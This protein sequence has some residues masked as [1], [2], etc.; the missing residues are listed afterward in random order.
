MKNPQRCCLALFVSLALAVPALVSAQGAT[1]A[2]IRGTVVDD[3]HAA[4]PGT[5]IVAT[6]RDTGAV[7]TTVTSDNGSY[8]LAALQVGT[9]DLRAELSG[10]A[11]VTQDGIRV[12]VGA[13]V[14]VDVILQVASLAEEITVE[15]RAP[16]LDTKSSNIAG[17]IEPAQ[18]ERLP[19]NGR[20]WLDLVALVP[21]A[22]GNPGMIQAGASG[23]DMA[24]YNVDGVD[25]SNQCCGG[26]NQGYSQENVSEFQ[27]LTNRF[28]AEYGRVG[29]LVINAVTKAG[30]NQ[31]RGTG[32]GFFRNDRFDA[33]N[34]FTNE[35]SPFDE[36]QVGM[37]GGGPLVRNRAHFFGS[38]EHQKRA[39]TA[40]PNTTIPEFDVAASQDI[41]RHYATGRF[42]VQLTDAHRLFVRGSIYN[43]EQLNVGVGGRTTLSGGYA[44]PSDNTD[45]SVG[46]TWLIGSRAVYEIRGGFSRIDNRLLSNSPTPLLNFPSAL[47]GSPT[48]SPQWW[49]EM[50]IQV[51]QALSYFLPG[52]LGEHAMKAGFQYFR[53]RFWGAF[54]PAYGSYRFDEDPAD[55][56]DPMTYPQPTSYTIP[57][58]DTSHDV[59][60]P[61]YAA[62]VQDNWTV[63]PALALNLGLRYDLETGTKNDDVEHPLEPGERP[64]DANNV[65]PRLGLAYDV[66]GNQRTVLRGGY[67]RYYDK[68]MLNLTSN[69]RRLVL[70]E[71]I[72]VTV[73]DPVFGDPLGGRTYDDFKAQGIPS[74]TIV[75]ARDFK[76]PVNDQVSVG[77][78]QQLGTRYALQVDYVRSR[79]RDE[80]MSPSVN[81]FQDPAT[82]LP[83]DPTIHGRP[84]P[85]YVRVTRY[86]STGG[87]AYDGLQVGV[88]GRPGDGAWWT[89]VQW[90]GSYTLSRT[91]DDHGSNRGGVPTNPFNLEDEWSYSSTDQRHRFVLNAVATLPYDVNLSII[92]FAGSERPINIGTN[93]DP[94]HLGYT[95]RWLDA[96]GDT[97]PR[98]G[99]RTEK[100]DRKLDLRVSK[101][102]NLG[103]VDV[104]GILEAFNLLN[105]W[106]LTSYGTRFGTDSYLQPASSTDPFYQPRQVQLGFRVS[107]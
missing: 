58:G 105:T 11:T 102:V 73:I 18:I 62:F 36:R 25:V 8:I 89:R 76:T 5:T 99:E 19:L 85:D 79:G 40:I 93:L 4:L 2:Q 60:N 78:A 84:H 53:P 32:F 81:F 39:V 51:N 9:Y 64:L 37:N 6:H 1:D 91:K 55:F 41:T 50:N 59:V 107:Y 65:S 75:I 21:G 22:R 74:D 106:N 54:Q 70:G 33:E 46:D 95:G 28:D 49:K 24:K 68:V 96:D 100:W 27:V 103:R 71:L 87:S 88:T 17:R 23:G 29:G 104:E 14:T 45:L 16:L 97:L 42:D 52:A 57:L 92:F 66:F 7:R 94:F 90:Q 44:R 82:N 34:P 56:N 12:G 38:Y 3:S 47:L 98:Y 30:T 69:E 35:V 10:F 43:W 63:T 13:S 86:Q 48:N 61:I 101:R 83:R 20:N 80:P 31:F 26:S 15:A 77:L 72:P 67:G